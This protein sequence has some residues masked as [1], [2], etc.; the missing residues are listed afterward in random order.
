MQNKNKKK[1]LNKGPYFCPQSG[2]ISLN[3]KYAGTKIK[4]YYI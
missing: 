2:I 4:G 3:I 1:T